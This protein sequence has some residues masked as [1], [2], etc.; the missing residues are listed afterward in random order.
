MPVL[1]SKL[2]LCLAGKDHKPAEAN[3]EVTVQS[4]CLQLSLLFR[5]GVF[6]VQG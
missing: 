5:K 2:Q 4:P 6:V 1:L 3:L